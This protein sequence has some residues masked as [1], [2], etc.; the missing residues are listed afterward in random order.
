MSRY[1]TSEAQRRASKKWD[2][3]NREYKR[4]RDYRSKGLKFIKE[5]SEKGDLEEFEYEIHQ[6]KETLKNNKQQND[7]KLYYIKKEKWN[8]LLLF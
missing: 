7:W 1:K 2:E 8:K 6:R 5:Y 4:I 3:E